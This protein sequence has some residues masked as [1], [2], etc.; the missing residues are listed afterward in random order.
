MCCILTVK[1]NLLQ[2]CIH[3]PT[4]PQSHLWKAQT[5]NYSHFYP[6]DTNI[7]HGHMPKT[8]LTRK[9]IYHRMWIPH[10]HIPNGL[11]YN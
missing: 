5:K 9:Y 1:N 4:M 3:P 7:A 8:P 6:P 11:Q 10:F 2:K